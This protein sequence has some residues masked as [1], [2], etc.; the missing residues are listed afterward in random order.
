LR[1]KRLILLFFLNWN[2]GTFLFWNISTVQTSTG[3]GDIR[4][5]HHHC[6]RSLEL[7]RPSPVPHQPPLLLPRFLCRAAHFCSG[8][9]LGRRPPRRWGRRARRRVRPLRVLPEGQELQPRNGK[10]IVRSHMLFRCC[11]VHG[12]EQ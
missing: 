4:H 9:Q 5:G 8:V 11:L 2:G 7:P 10:F 1:R 3:T 12:M 6:R